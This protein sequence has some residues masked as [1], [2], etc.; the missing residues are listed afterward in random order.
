MNK[1]YLSFDVGIQNLAFCLLEKTGDLEFKI[2]NWGIISFGDDSKKLTCSGLNRGNKPCK[3]TPTFSKDDKHYCEKHSKDVNKDV[4]VKEIIKIEEKNLKCVKCCK[5]A[6]FRFD[7]QNYCKADATSAK[8]KYDK[9]NSLKKIK[10]VNSNH[11][12]LYELAPKL[13]KF[14][15]EKADF[16]TA[17]EILIE[18]QPTFDNPTMKSISIMIFSYFILRTDTR[19]NKPSLHFIS[20]SNKLKLSSKAVKEVDDVKKTNTDRKKYELTKDLGVQICQEIIKN[21][22]VNLK[23]I[24]SVKKK[25]D[26]CDAFLQAYH[27]IFCV[28]GVPKDIEEILNKLVENHIKKNTGIDVLEA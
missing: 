7:D 25:D 16:L 15:D 19:E 24:Q 3:A 23:L 2:K 22:E 10:K 21:D 5:R 28:N 18:N 27:Y 1:T 13:F 11:I 8:K 14:L 4:E 9:D 12:P 6:G 26:M 17:D 20:P